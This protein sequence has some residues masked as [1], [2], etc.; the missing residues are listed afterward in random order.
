MTSLSLLF[1]RQRCNNGQATGLSV[2]NVGRGLT[3]SLCANSIKAM[4]S[5]E[6]YNELTDAVIER[7]VAFSVGKE[8]MNL[9]HA[10]LGKMY[11]VARLLDSMK[12]SQQRLSEDPF[13]EAARLCRFSR[14]NVARLI[15]FYTVKDKE[16]HFN[17]ELIE[18]R[19]SILSTL[20][21]E[22]LATLLMIVLTQ[23]SSDRFIKEYGIDKE[24]QLVQ[25]I[26][27]HKRDKGNL[28]FGGKTVY[29]TLIDSACERYGWS[30]D[31]V[32]WGISYTNLRMITADSVVSMYLSKEDMKKLHVSADREVID[33]SDPKNFEKIKAMLEE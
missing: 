9:F 12:V 3:S 4:E 29:G 10:S 23:D 6:I 16:D 14:E 24:R 2:A 28:S 21:D 25:K 1:L 32:V 19:C 15:S 26:V 11:L 17:N 5:R 31:Y 18:H 27:K 8:R 30:F 13:S 33:A 20:N 7:P 22:E